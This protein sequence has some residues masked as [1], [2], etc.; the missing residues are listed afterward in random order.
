MRDSMKITVRYQFL[1][2]LFVQLAASGIAFVFGMIAFWYFT[3]IS[4]AKEIL[5]LIFM[6]VNFVLLYTSSKRFATLDNKPYTPLKPSKIKAVLF[7]CLIVL[8]NLV[9][10]AVYKVI[11][12]KYAADTGLS[13]V[14][15]TILNILFYCWSF[16]YNGI[17]NMSNGYLTV[18]SVI[19]MV[20]VPVSA[21][22]AG[23]IAGLKKFDITEKMDKF[24]YEKDND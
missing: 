24:I 6:L 3:N 2:M 7:G 15:P 14:I 16:P 8:V 19:A 1:Y 20:V 9:F 18:Y 11:W 10:V 22:L 4:V 23:Y 13:G 21:T 5:S 12:I 17:M